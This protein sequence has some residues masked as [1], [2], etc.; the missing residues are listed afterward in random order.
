MDKKY[1]ENLWA[2]ADSGFLLKPYPDP[3]FLWNLD[4]D[5]DPGIYDQ[6][7]VKFYAVEQ[8]SKYY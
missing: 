8:N 2:Q 4:Q 1:F 3:G 6:K 7:S 5:Q